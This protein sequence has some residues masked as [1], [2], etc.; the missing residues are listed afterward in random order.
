MSASISGSIAATGAEWPT[1]LA[2]LL[3]VYTY[4]HYFFASTTAQVREPDRQTVLVNH[5]NPRASFEMRTRERTRNVL[6]KV[7][8]LHHVSRAP[9]CLSVTCSS[10]FTC[11]GSMFDE[12]RDTFLCGGVVVIPFHHPAVNAVVSPVLA[13]LLASACSGTHCTPYRR[14]SCTLP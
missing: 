5:G 7:G 11:P 3:V 10:V 12:D 2:C 13:T 6:Q 4:S 8:F 1:A 14:R 9:H